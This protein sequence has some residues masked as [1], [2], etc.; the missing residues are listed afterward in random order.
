MLKI[1]KHALTGILV[2]VEKLGYSLMKLSLNKVVIK[3][4]A[5]SPVIK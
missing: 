2:P 5:T 1:S 4:L 3:L